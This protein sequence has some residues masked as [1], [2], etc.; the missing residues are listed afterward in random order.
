M[1]LPAQLQ[2]KHWLVQLWVMQGSM[3]WA[4]PVCQNCVLGRCA[5][6]CFDHSATVCMYTHAYILIYMNKYIHP[7]INIPIQNHVC[8][9]IHKPKLY[10]HKMYK[11]TY[12]Y[13]YS[14]MSVF[15]QTY[16]HACNICMHAIIHMDLYTH[17]HS[18][19]CAWPHAY[20]A[21]HMHIYMCTHI[22][23]YFYVYKTCMLAVLHI[24]TYTHTDSCLSV[25]M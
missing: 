1:Q 22:H 13:I 4:E 23:T 9:L 24:H 18:N 15:I 2:W 20:L 8:L 21:T 16:L 6:L 10:I 19:T 7:C 5:N 25:Y 17:I 11:H 14:C 12:T 3:L